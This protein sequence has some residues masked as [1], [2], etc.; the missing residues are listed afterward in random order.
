MGR[1][2][3]K[4]GV[5]PL[6][7]KENE[8][9]GVEDRE[10]FYGESPTIT[11]NASDDSRTPRFDRDVHGNKRLNLAVVFSGKTQDVRD[12]AND[13]HM[14]SAQYDGVV[15]F[16]KVSKKFIRIEEDDDDENLL[17]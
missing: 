13:V 5:Y 4:R 3:S 14:I 15:R 10:V 11:D 16:I 17:A 6:K 9:D 12:L 8:T 7:E 2:T 1:K